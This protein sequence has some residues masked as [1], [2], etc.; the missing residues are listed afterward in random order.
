[1][2]LL[3]VHGFRIFIYKLTENNK[4]HKQIVKYKNIKQIINKNI[5][6]KIQ[7]CIDKTTQQCYYKTIKKNKR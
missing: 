3:E 7:K 5:N 4:K 2:W 6:I 1:M